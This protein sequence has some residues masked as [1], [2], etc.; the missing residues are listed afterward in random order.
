M[1]P[2]S[3]TLTYALSSIYNIGPGRSSFSLADYH[4]TGNL[5][6][7]VD[8]AEGVVI[9]AGNPDGTF[10]ASNA[11]SALA[12]GLGAVAGKF[13]NAANNPTGNVDVMVATGTTQARLLSGLVLP[14]EAQAQLLKGNGDGTFAALSAPV[15]TSGG[16]A[17]IPNNVWSN[18]VPGDYD[19]DNNLDILFSMTGLPQP[20][21][22]GSFPIWYVM[23]GNGDGT[24]NQSGPTLSVANATSNIDGYYLESVGGDFNGDGISDVAISDDSFDATAVGVRNNRAGTGPDPA[25]LYADSSNTASTRLQRDFS[26]AAEAASRTWF[27]SRG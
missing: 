12:P 19:G 4:T 1:R 27:L 25:F 23:Y 3:G 20:P 7:A 15:N 21:P 22:S 18:L 11:Y 8:S 17:N 14:N 6:L 26:R 13:R 10:V 5:D 2:Q 24:F 16:P 9:F